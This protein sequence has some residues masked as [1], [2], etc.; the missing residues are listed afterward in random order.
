MHPGEKVPRS[1]KE[2]NEKTAVARFRTAPRLTPA[3][4]ALGSFSAL[5]VALYTSQ[6]SPSGSTYEVLD[7]APFT[8]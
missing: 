6:L 3:V 1:R 7:S 5:D 8:A 2:R 4:P